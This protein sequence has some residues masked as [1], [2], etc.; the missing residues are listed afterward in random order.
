M[1]LL[2]RRPPVRLGL[3]AAEPV[4]RLRGVEIDDTFAEAF[5]MKAT[6]LVITAH[7]LAWARH[8][9]VSATGMATSVIGCGCAS[10]RPR[11]SAST[12][13][14]RTPAQVWL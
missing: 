10:T 11:K 5:A 13:A 2:Q 1:R 14:C 7:D 6:R 3:R 8:A 9:A 4:M 12:A